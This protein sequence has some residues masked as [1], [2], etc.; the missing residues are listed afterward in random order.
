ML[1]IFQQSLQINKEQINEDKCPVAS[2]WPGFVMVFC[3]GLFF[4][5]TSVLSGKRG[6]VRFGWRDRD[7]GDGVGRGNVTLTGIIA[8]MLISLSELPDEHEKCV[9]FNI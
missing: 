3:S 5:L 2:G 9:P 8:I 1:V 4:H 7:E 6:F